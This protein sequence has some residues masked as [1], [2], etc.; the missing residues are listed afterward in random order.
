MLQQLTRGPSAQ[1]LVFS[2]SLAENPIGAET[3]GSDGDSPSQVTCWT[4][5]QFLKSKV[6]FHKPQIG[7]FYRDAAEAVP[8]LCSLRVHEI[9]SPRPTRPTDP[10]RSARFF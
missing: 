6:E 4:Y 7:A 10:C 3:L 5:P 9:L 8:A 2:Y 1:P